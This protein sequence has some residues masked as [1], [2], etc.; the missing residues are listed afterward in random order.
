MKCSMICLYLLM[1]GSLWG[2][3]RGAEAGYGYGFPRDH[4]AH[5]EFKTE[6]WYFTG[7]LESEDGRAF[8]YQL[9]FFRQGV[10]EPGLAAEATSRFVRPAIYF[11]H[12]ALT[13]VTGR[14]FR[15]AQKLSRGAFGEAGDSEE[16]SEERVAWIDG[17]ELRREG[18]GFRV[19]AEMEGVVL[20]LEFEALK[21]PV[22]HGVDGIS[23]KAEGKGNASHYYSMTRL[24]TRGMLVVGGEVLP[25]TGESWFDREWGSSQLGDDQVG[26]D[27]F[28][29]QFDDGSEL[30]IYRLRR[31][32][33]STDRYSGGTLVAADGTSETL[34][35]D[36]FLLTPGAIW[37][38]GATGAEYPVAWRVSVPG[39]GIEIE[40]RA[41]MEAQELSFSPVSYWEGVVGVTGTREGAPLRGRGY[42]EMTGYAGELGVLR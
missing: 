25:V 26:W 20:E 21:A 29:L 18:E 31:G 41:A 37:K 40:V 38:S 42:L 8:G 16:P 27:W 2:E 5:R 3:W 32:D 34:G 19:K 36:D 39:R 35:A 1:G 33:G 10:M 4:Y 28:S 30:M 23:Q 6:W 13:D 15:F 17:W 9:T 22:L 11:A 12:F 24:A 14:R 7:H